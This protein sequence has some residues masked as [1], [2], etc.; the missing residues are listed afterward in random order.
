MEDPILYKYRSLQ[1]FKNFI[2]I[3]LKSRLYASNYKELNDPMEGQFYFNRGELNPRLLRKLSEGK[4]SLRVC[5]L[6]RKS[7]SELM[8]SHYADG[9]HGVA[10]G[11]QID[12]S[13]YQ[14]Y[15]IQYNGLAYLLSDQLADDTAIE[16]LTHKLEIWNY[17]EEERIFISDGFYVD[18]TVK[19]VITGRAMSAQDYSLVKELVSV[20]NPSIEILKAETIMDEGN[21]VL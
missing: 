9:Q 3:V 6:S 14:V 19:Q 13:K 15:P 4:S 16:V 8:W 21:F 10:V 2:D 7:N 17:E 12:R 11:V 5:S 20:I 18:V 1:N